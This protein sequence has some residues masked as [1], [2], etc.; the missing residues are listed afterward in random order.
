LYNTRGAA[1]LLGL[2]I[3][4]LNLAIIFFKTKIVFL[5]RGIKEIY[6]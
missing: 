1:I 2:R 3:M 4:A 6:A 5:L